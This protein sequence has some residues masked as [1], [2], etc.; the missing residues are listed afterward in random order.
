MV[1]RGKLDKPE[2]A[3]VAEHD[4]VSEGVSRDIRVGDAGA[5]A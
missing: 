3:S 4:F 5:G 1:Y 2:P